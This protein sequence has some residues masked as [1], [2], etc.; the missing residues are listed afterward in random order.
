M[1]KWCESAKMTRK[2][3]QNDEKV[4]PKWRESDDKMTRKWWQ[5]DEK[6]MTKWRES[7]DKM[8]RKWWRNNDDNDDEIMTK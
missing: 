7:D 4:M 5:N 1:P 2:W 3:C 6:V 8:T